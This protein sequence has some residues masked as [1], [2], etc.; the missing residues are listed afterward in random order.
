[1]KTITKHYNWRQCK[2]Q[3]I[4]RRP[5]PKHESTLK[6]PNLWLK[7]CQEKAE[8]MLQSGCQEVCCGTV[9]FRN[10]YKKKT[11]TMAISMNMLL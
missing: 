3:Q 2:Y 11:G 1:M 10:V 4:V 8:S 5:T 7:K 6:L 9:S